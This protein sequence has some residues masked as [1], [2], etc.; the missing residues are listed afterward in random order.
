MKPVARTRFIVIALAGAI[1]ACDKAQITSAPSFALAG[2]T[3]RFL[4]A[5]ASQDGATCGGVWAND[6]YNLAIT[7]TDNG[8]GTFAMHT[9]YLAGSFV[10]IEGPSPSK[11]GQSPHGTFVEGGIKGHFTGFID[12]TIT[13]ATYNPDACHTGGGGPGGQATSPCNTRSG[14][15]AAVFGASAGVAY[16]AWVFEYRSNDQ[17]LVFNYWRDSYADTPEGVGDIATE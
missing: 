15:I 16:G 11:C 13:S 8:N 6:E 7:V 2:K 9:E 14:F 1:F 12:N 10:T 3:D 17:R 5:G 4:L